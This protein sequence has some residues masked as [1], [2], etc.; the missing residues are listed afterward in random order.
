MKITKCRITCAQTIH[1]VTTYMLCR[2]VGGDNTSDVETIPSPWT[3]VRR[4]RSVYVQTEDTTSD[5]KSDKDDNEVTINENCGNDFNDENKCDDFQSVSE[6]MIS[7][8]IEV[9]DNT[10]KNYV[11]EEG[12][13][14]ESSMD[15][16]YEDS[17][18]VEKRKLSSN[19]EDVSNY[20][21]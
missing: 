19:E 20:L 16:N 1:Y 14:S 10:N 6:E 11:A 18:T 21:K 2:K 5:T 15:V 17:V 13:A 4:Q 9:C 12:T 8:D 7:E 3:P